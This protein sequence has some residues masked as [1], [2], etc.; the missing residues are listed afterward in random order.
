MRLA[1][2]MSK[3]E[4]DCI[5]KNLFIHALAGKNAELLNRDKMGTLSRTMGYERLREKI[6]S[7]GSVVFVGLDPA[8]GLS[9]GDEMDQ[10]HQRMLGKTV[11]DLAV[12]TGSCVML[13]S[14]ASKASGQADE[15]SSHTSRGGGAIT[16]AV[17]GEYT[18]RSMTA[19][20]AREAGISDP[21]ERRRH[22][23]LVCTK[24]NHVP[25][26]AFVPE[27]LRRGDNGILAAACIEFGA[28]EA[29]TPAD[30]RAHGV[31]VELAAVRVPRFSEWRDACVARNVFP[32]KSDEAVKKAMQ[33]TIRRLLNGGY[34]TKGMG[35]GVYLPARDESGDI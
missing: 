12:T 1:M 11:D 8:L 18:L 22:V 32:A 21:E 28:A 34:I 30:L 31:L 33:R 4:I 35:N 2:N 29:A 19:N 9:G 13:N 24:G 26:V 15:P 25:P 23:Q 20:E 7:I 14:H 5:K 27:W 17:R 10:H 6:L 3:D 16:D